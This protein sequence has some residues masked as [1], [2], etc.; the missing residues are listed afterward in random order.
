MEELICPVLG[1]M[2]AFLFVLLF[3]FKHHK[4]YL[5]YFLVNSLRSSDHTVVYNGLGNQDSA[6][7]SAH[8]LLMLTLFL[9]FTVTPPSDLIVVVCIDLTLDIFC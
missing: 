6:S 8:R 2:P 7:F 1:G 4:I 3:L 5:H 9:S